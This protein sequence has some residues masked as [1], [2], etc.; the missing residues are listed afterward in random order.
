MQVGAIEELLLRAGA[1]FQRQ[2]PEL[3]HPEV[4]CN[5]RVTTLNLHP[6]HRGTTDSQRDSMENNQIS[7]VVRLVH[8][9]SLIET[10]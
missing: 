9:P 1:A 4:A 8:I 5:D 10:P 3:I 2:H 6:T 7:Q